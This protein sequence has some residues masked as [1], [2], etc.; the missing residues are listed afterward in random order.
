MLKILSKTKLN[1]ILTECQTPGA[2]K[3]LSYTKNGV[4]CEAA[5]QTVYNIFSSLDFF[6]ALGGKEQPL[7]AVLPDGNA[8]LGVV[9]TRPDGQEQSRMY[10]SARFRDTN[11]LN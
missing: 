4:P 3:I 8:M 1:S 11:F 7:Y 9:S 5:A 10:F 2:V 6:R